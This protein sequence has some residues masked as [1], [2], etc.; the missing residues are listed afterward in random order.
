MSD[1]LRQ[2]RVKVYCPKCEELY[3]PQLSNQVDGA[4]FGSSLAH[5]FFQTYQKVI[6]LPPKVYFFEPTLFGFKVAGKRGSKFYQPSRGEITDT[7]ARQ[8]QLEKALMPERGQTHSQ[9]RDAAHSQ[10]KT[11]T[12]RKKNAAERVNT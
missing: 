9:A 7:A 3:I 12:R 5:I 6:V 8:R 1:K 4:F 10:T 11:T 2:N